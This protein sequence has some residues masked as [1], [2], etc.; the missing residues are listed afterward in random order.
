MKT[1][2]G[3]AVLTFL[4]LLG[5][6][7]IWIAIKLFGVGP[8]VLME[9]EVLFAVLFL[10]PLAAYALVVGTLK[11]FGVLGLKAKFGASAKE[12]IE[13]DFG[14]IAPTPADMHEV[15]KKGFS[16]LENMLANY[17]LSE[18]KP[19]VMKIKLGGGDYPREDTLA[20]IENL[21]RYRS[22]RSVVFL[23]ANDEVIA[24]MAPWAARQILSDPERGSRFLSIVTRD[25]NHAELFE[26]SPHVLRET[27][28]VGDS[29][30][31]ALQRMAERNL[32]AIVV[33]DKKNRLKGVAERD[34]L[35]NKLVAKLIQ[36]R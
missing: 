36:A 18:T 16:A 3:L 32:E 30:R 1:L 8:E 26:E 34:R 6:A 14:A 25:N 12:V 9:H 13:L 2:K 7:A 29:G 11:E 22:F 35:I 28:E 20:F 21:S 24:Y 31:S 33:V 15:G 4:L 10:G 5:L 23:D 17:Q 19:I 27:I